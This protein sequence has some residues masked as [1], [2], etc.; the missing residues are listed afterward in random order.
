MEVCAHV[1]SLRVPA[2]VIVC[3]C[4][5]ALFPAPL[6][7]APFSEEI[8]VPGGTSAVSRLLGLDPAPER[9][10][11]MTELTRVIYDTPEGTSAATDALSLKLT[12]YL[13]TT[14]QLLN[15][16]RAVQP[17]GQSIALSMAANRNDRRRLEVFLEGVG[18]RLRERNRIFAVERLDTRQAV[19]RSAILVSLGIDTEQLAAR[20]NRGEDVRVDVRTETVPVP[21]SV[22]VWSDAVLARPLAI[23]DLFA[24]LIADRQ[25][26]LLSHGLAAL[27]DET[28]AFFG[29]HPALLKRLY[30]RDAGVFA[31]FAGSL[32]IRNNTIV[33]PGG[34]VAWPLWEAVVGE[35]A[36][37]PERFIRE[38]FGRSEGRVAYLYDAVARFDPSTRAFALGL[39]I[40]DRIHRLERFRALVTA[41]SAFPGWTVPQRAFR[42]P[43]DDPV[44]LLLRVS[45]EA[46]GEPKRPAWRTFWSQVFESNDLPNDPDRR[47]RSV[48]QQGRID[49][50]WLAE[51]ILSADLPSRGERL[52]QLAFGL[53]AFSGA[54]DRALPDVL[55]AVRGLP[56]YR[57]LMLGLER[58]G[59][60]NPAVY[61][62]AVRHAAQLSDLGPERGH[63]ALSQFQGAL[64][65]VTRLA[66][67][68]VLDAGQTES[69]VR[70]LSAVPFTDG[71]YA[72]GI[73]RWLRS[74]LAPAIG[75]TA[76][77]FDAQLIASLAGRRRGASSAP[78]LVSWEQRTYA[79]D[80]ASSEARRL[81]RG[82]EMLQPDP[83]SLAMD[84]ESA[85]Q[86][87]ASSTLTVAR[88]Q[89]VADELKAL[90]RALD[91]R[92]DRRE[93]LRRA[94][95]DLSKITTS[96]DLKDATQV[97]D[98][99]H[100]LADD[101][102]AGALISM[103]YALHS[104]IPQATTLAASVVRRH[105][106]GF[107]DPIP[108]TRVRTAWAEPV[109]K[110]Q[111]GVPWHVSGS[112]LGLDLGL[113]SLALRR[114]SLGA[115]PGPPTLRSTD[116]D[117]FTK[118]IALLN[119]FTLH[120]TDRDE[121]ARAIARG[122]DRIARLATR[123]DTLDDIAE[124]ISF[125]GWRRRA[126]QWS[127]VNDPQQVLGYFSLTEL[128]HLGKPLGQ[129]D[130]KAWGVAASSHD[131][132]VCTV[133][134]PPGQWI[135]STG[136]WPRGT[137]ATHMADLNLRVALALTEL[138]LPAALARGVLAAATQDYVDRVKPLYPDDWL[139]LVRSAQALSTQKLQDYIATLT[140]NGP[141]VAG[142]P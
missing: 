91:G 90:Q 45:A 50:A 107:A 121:I 29:S 52:D 109:Q 72:G 1:A 36:A 62:A 130:L 11:F 97:S 76:G 37:R 115:L 73:A 65:I 53:R 75:I 103:V 33:P 40:D 119:E 110:I 9:A 2:A 16:L 125:D 44:A 47:L 99:L 113:S 30:D 85:A 74:S 82:L 84:V 57:M 48:E 83:V 64:A 10:R 15:A 77:S 71:R 123:P 58:M 13:Q 70:S 69:L 41:M 114:T 101:V 32:R 126:V 5:L 60:A 129:A 112:L 43:A 3:I 66:T 98:S 102:V 92:L 27:D 55:V 136:R 20:L 42:R 131:G 31:A 139:T 87:L 122:R 67:T 89:A 127:L 137:V 104:G 142:D 18:L 116:K 95:Q 35:P 24:A 120:D 79:L 4:S 46:N 7:A 63:V 133:L 14:D 96:R 86:H 81:T 17:A 134:T 28:L 6:A 54:D 88:V 39:W 128:L 68:K 138:K 117:V 22:K 80:L 38:L 25:A 56:R 34:D 141:L 61:A 106:F 26:A 59:I 51:S 111:P 21:L 23:D 100:A 108:D 8:P 49:A 78:T 140:A 105:D 19:D 12:T 93:A 118:T 135:L 94:L 124:D 132:C